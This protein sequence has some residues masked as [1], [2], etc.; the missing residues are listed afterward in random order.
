MTSQQIFIVLALVLAI[1]LDFALIFWLRR[2]NKQRLVESAPADQIVYLLGTYSPVLTWL[3]YRRLP[4]PASGK[5]TAK[6]DETQVIKEVAASDERIGA[7]EA[8]VDWAIITGMVF[9]FCSIFLNLGS[10][11]RLPGLESEFFQILD[12]ILVNSLRNFHQFPLWNP[13]NLTG[14]PYIADPMLHI[15]N[16]VVTVPVLLFGVQV[17]YKLAIF[18]SFLLAALGMWWLGAVLGLGRPARIWMALMYAFA[19]QPVA[20]F[21]QGEFLFVLAFAWIPWII[22]SLILVTKTRRRAHI[23]LTAIF[24]A[25]FFFCGNAY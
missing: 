11:T 12:W 3:K 15:Y 2:K 1:G 24:M 7:K 8:W 16:P 9:L 14:L 5:S 6:A 22:A 21:F 17:G 4:Q 19:G 20:R 25:L 18:F 13:Y 10:S 23:A